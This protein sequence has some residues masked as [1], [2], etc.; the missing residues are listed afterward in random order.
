MNI[1]DLVETLRKEGQLV[2]IEE[3][4]SWNL[5]AAAFTSMAYRVENGK[6]ASLFNNVKG[7]KDKGRIFGGAFASSRRRSWERSAVIL[8]MPRETS[9]PDYRD[10]FIRRIEHPL[11]PIVL[12]AGDALCKENVMMGADINLFNFPWPYIHQVD[13]GR[14][15]TA[16]STQIVEDP[17][18]G[19]VNW[20]NYRTMML[21]KNRF[22]GLMVFGQHG[23]T[24]F[25]TKWEARGEPCPFCY[26]VGGDTAILYAA[27]LPLPAGVCEADYAGGLREEPL[28]VVQAETNKLFVPADAEIVIEGV[29]MPGER[30]D[31]GPTGEYTGYVHSRAPMPVY[32]VQCIT[33]RDNPIIP[34]SVEGVSFNDNMSVFC[35]V[36]G[37]EFYRALINGGFPVREVRGL[38]EASYGC[39]VISTEVPYEGYIQDLRNFIDSHKITIWGTGCIFVD[40]DVDISGEDMAEKVLQ[41]IGT[42]LDPKRDIYRTDNDVF[43]TPVSPMIDVKARV[44]G[45][46]GARWVWDAT[47]PRSWSKAEKIKAVDIGDLFPEDAINKSNDIYNNLEVK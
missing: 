33:Y 44:S 12:E 38:N 26:V 47:T 28:R 20:G 8:G 3:E 16:H 21:S 11:K 35:S 27:G 46:G 36:T 18:T 22:T 4:V 9:W 13:G 6:G 23:P 19:W 42:K 24:I 41:E 1:R 14:Y 37:A 30:A 39:L 40:A 7:Y 32:H 31:E 5:E 15:A 2:E 34:M 43:A 10:E 25:Y 45:V 29:L 17:D